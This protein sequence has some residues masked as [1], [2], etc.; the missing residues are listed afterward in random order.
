MTATVI[1]LGLGSSPVRQTY[2]I[3]GS[4]EDSLLP[5]AAVVDS[6]C[7]DCEKG[8]RFVLDTTTARLIELDSQSPTK[9]AS[10][11][12]VLKFDTMADARS[13][14]KDAA[15]L[16]WLSDPGRLVFAIDGDVAGP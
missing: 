7:T 14:I 3:S 9:P 12:Y 11:A 2:N 13:W 10:E 1:I 8:K 6:P 15:H 16:D 4:L 5:Y